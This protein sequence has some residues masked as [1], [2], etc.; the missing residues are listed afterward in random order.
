MTEQLN[1]W[2][3]LSWERT[4]M[5]NKDAN[6]VAAKEEAVDEGEAQE[7]D[8]ASDAN[9]LLF[10]VT[11]DFFRNIVNIITRAFE[12]FLVFSTMHG[13]ASYQHALQLLDLHL[14]ALV[15]PYKPHLWWDCEDGAI[16]AL[17]LSLS[18]VSVR[19]LYFV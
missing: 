11:A 14:L 5:I 17:S 1:Q 8:A 19:L 6:S 7:G 3:G 15:T 12:F 10:T 4:S 16:E 18:T 13:G 2:T 9:E